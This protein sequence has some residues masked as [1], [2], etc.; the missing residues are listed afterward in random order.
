VESPDLDPASILAA[1]TENG[2]EFVVIGGLAA[3]AHGSI[4][5]TYDIDIVP[6]TVVD[7]LTRLSAALRQLG[8]RIRTD[9]VEGGLPFDHDAE[10]L[11]AASVWNLTTP[12]GDLDITFTPSGT[13]GY[14]DL[15]KDA[16]PEPFFGV[17]VHI[18]SLAD[19]IR[20]KQAANRPKDQRALPVLREILA[21]RDLDTN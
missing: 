20:S 18:A 16:D 17:V 5:P 1:L 9:A 15:I 7:N 6:R 19:V 8:A 14:P 4:I 3:A 11:A 21:N 12:H 13:Q 2:V 10:S